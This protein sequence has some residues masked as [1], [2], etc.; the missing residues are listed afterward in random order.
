MFPATIFD[1]NGVLVDDE[2]VHLA[3]FQDVLGTLG[4]TLSEADYWER[5]LGFDDR[6]A[7]E[8]ILIDNGRSASEA[9][10]RRLVEAKR[11]SYLARARDGLRTFPGAGELVRRRAAGGPVVIVS[12]ALRPEIEHGL[13]VLGVSASVAAIVSAEDTTRSKPDSEGYVL[14]VQALARHIDR[15]AAARAVVIE[16]SISGV[17]AAKAAG[18][19]CVAVGHS[20]PLPDL[21]RAGADLDGSEDLGRH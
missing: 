10:V 4:L 9:E 14:G 21:A 6:G 11:P 2:L 7:F 19:A 5:Y 12:G 1:Y 18:L 20:Y 15:A 16:D 17:E 8:A 13:S 3:S